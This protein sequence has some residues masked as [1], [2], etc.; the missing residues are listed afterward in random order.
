M[1][2]VTEDKGGGGGGGSTSCSICLDAVLDQGL[3]SIAK[4]L[5][6][7]HFHLDCIGSAFN[8]KGEMQCPN[9]RKIEKGRWLYA[10]GHRSSAEFDLDGWLAED[11]LDVSYPELVDYV[12]TNV[13]TVELPWSPIRGFTQATTLYREREPHQNAYN[14]PIGSTSVRDHSNASSSTHVCPYMGLHG[15]PPT[16]HPAPSSYT[17]STPENAQFPHHADSLAR[18]STSYMI[19]SNGSTTDVRNYD[20][21]QQPPASHSGMRLSRD[22][23]SYQQRLG[24]YV[25]P[26]PIGPSSAAR[27]NNMFVPVGAPLTGEAA[28]GYT[29]GHGSHIYQQSVPQNSFNSGH[30][31]HIYTSGHGSHI[32][33]QSGPRSSQLAPVRRR[34]RPRA[35]SPLANSSTAGTGGMFGS[36]NRNTQD[37][38]NAGSSSYSWGLPLPWI[39]NEQESQWWGPL[40]PNPAPQTRPQELPRRAA[41]QRSPQ[42][43]SENGYQ[44][45][46]P[47][48]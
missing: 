42:G 7:H 39:P 17:D 47:F 32:Y 35:L 4:L 29:S 16:I 38:E 25:H 12:L 8:A 46:P 22:A 3:R 14:E 43:R 30:G 48:G 36:V 23:T 9:C 44:R 1:D 6:G 15:F 20:W 21:L 33:Q 28:S 37:N 45:M 11:F 34:V 41:P 40:N 27:G 2:L 13:Q 31:S 24:S 18:Q 19:N 5:C 26:H 10:N